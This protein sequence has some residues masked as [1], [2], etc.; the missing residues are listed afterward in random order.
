MRQN[1]C[2]FILMILCSSCAGVYVPPARNVPMFTK[3]GEFNGNVSFG[4][5]GLNVQ[6]AYSVTNHLG[7]MANFQT[8]TGQG[9]DM[10][11]THSSGE[12]GFGYYQRR[13]NIF[14]I[15]GGYGIGKGHGNDFDF[16]LSVE[17]SEV[18]GQYQRFFLQPS[19]G[20]Y[21]SRM[22]WAFTGRFTGVYFDEVNLFVNGAPQALSKSPR[23][24]FEPSFTLKSYFNERFY[25]WTQAGLCAQ[26]KENEKDNA[27]LDK[28]NV[29]DYE[30]FQVLVGV[31]VKLSRK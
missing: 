14:E 17:D 15:Y 12:I 31:G 18:E 4:T 25:I 20:F 26:F 22:E 3:G 13:R 2:C 5:S 23:Y 29:Q 16:G 1:V 24:F 8:S 30:P 6:T 7:V 9:E 19:I 11:R 27:T 10:I 28:F 21:N